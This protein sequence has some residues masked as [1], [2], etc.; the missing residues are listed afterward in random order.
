MKLF[1]NEEAIEYQWSEGGYISNNVTSTGLL[2]VWFL[3]AAHNKI[4]PK[5]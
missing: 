5:Q 2:L 1:E 3:L 4:Q